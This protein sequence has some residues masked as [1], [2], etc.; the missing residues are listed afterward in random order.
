[1]KVSIDRK[2]AGIFVRQRNLFFAGLLCF[3]FHSM[4]EN[5]SSDSLLKRVL[6]QLPIHV[7]QRHS[8]QNSRT[9]GCCIDRSVNGRATY[10]H[11]ANFK[12]R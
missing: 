9:K 1:M 6:I 11:F 10:D 3:F 4:Q 8:Q 2:I 5:V 12:K 7:V